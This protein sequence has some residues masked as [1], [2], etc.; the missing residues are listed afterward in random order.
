MD[1]SPPGSSVSEIFQARILEQVIISYSKGSS[2][3][4]DW[5]HVSCIGMQILDHWATCVLKK[6]PQTVKLADN[7]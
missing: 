4:R 6:F 2:W 3:P 5:I 7:I 1:Y